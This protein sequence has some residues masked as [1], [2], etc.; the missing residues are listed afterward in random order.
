MSGNPAAPCR[1]A[2]FA[3]VKRIFGCVV[4]LIILVFGLSANAACASTLSMRTSSDG[5]VQRVG[6]E[7]CSEVSIQELSSGPRTRELGESRELHRS[8]PPAFGYKGPAR[9]TSLEFV[10][11]NTPGAAGA[12]GEGAA[13]ATSVGDSLKG[14]PKGRSPGVRTVGSDAELDQVFEDMSRGGTP[15]QRPGYGGSSGGR[16]VRLPDGTEVGLRGGSDSGGRTIDVRYPGASG[17]GPKVH[18]R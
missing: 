16:A 7:Q 1:R 6:W 10:A 2:Y 11:T 8:R 15:M 18:I 12:A 3:L 17:T 4:F 5:A 13:D 9:A 14:L